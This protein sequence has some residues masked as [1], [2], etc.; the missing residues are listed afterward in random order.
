MS[1]G[2]K[3][4]IQ[5]AI[6]ILG[7]PGAGKGTQGIVLGQIPR[8]YHFACGDVFRQLD[9]RTELGQQFVDYS[10]KGDLVP[11]ELTIKLWAA[12]ME[13]RINSHQY[14]PD[15]DI[16]VLDGI[17]RNV[18]QAEML[19][20]HVKIH[21]VFH[22]SCPDRDELARR[23]RKRAL[24]DNRI[25]D[26]SEDVIQRRIKLYEDET[27]PILEYYPDEIRSDI[28]AT[29]SPAKV[30]YDI[31]GRLQTLDVYQKIASLTV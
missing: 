25:D 29:Q 18:E 4:D 15:I 3:N 30:L 31:L 10:R 21:H 20:K 14:K 16:L 17:P 22:L 8:F 13:S 1:E 2:D 28:D 5:P 24:K 11:D 7:A 23:M 12:H 26:A 9:T 27:K 6:L 19:S